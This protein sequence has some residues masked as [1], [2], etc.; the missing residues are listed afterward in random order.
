MKFLT[1]K[2]DG[3]PRKDGRSKARAFVVTKPRKYGPVTSQT[4]IST[5]RPVLITGAHA[6]GK[7]YWLD[8]LRKDAARVWPSLAGAEPLYLAAV[9]SVSDWTDGKHL[10]SWWSERS[11]KT[12]EDRH[13]KKLSAGERQ[14]ALPDYL[15]ETGAVL[16]VDDAHKLTAKKLEIVRACART[17]KV[18]VMTA[19]D[20]GRLSPSLRKDVLW[21]EPQTFRLDTDVAYDATPIFMWMAILIA[22]S[23]GSYELAMALGGLKL[24]AGGRRAAKQA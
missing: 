20:E 17:A 21:L 8:R 14:R 4:E 23:T 24:L 7:S 22:V 6:S 3:R 1:I 15:K 9:W 2:N 16:F 19:S 13:W 11:Q 18:W 12:G 5:K 10:E